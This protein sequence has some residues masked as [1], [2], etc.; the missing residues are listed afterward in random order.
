MR[1]RN[2]AARRALALFG[3]DALASLPLLGGA[4]ATVD[5][6]LLGATAAV[7]IALLPVAAGGLGLLSWL[8]RGI[9][10]ALWDGRAV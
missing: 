5:A 3:V 6:R 1:V 7:A 8:A 9:L 4:A 10:L 2:G